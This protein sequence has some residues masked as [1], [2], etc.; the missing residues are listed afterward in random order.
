[1]AL[2]LSVV[3]AHLVCVIRKCNQGYC[4][5]AQCQHGSPGVISHALKTCITTVLPL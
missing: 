5:Q 3:V 4:K 1:M 2:L